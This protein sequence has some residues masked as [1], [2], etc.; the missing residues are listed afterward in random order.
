VKFEIA[1]TGAAAEVDGYAIARAL[2]LRVFQDAR[3]RGFQ[4]V[5]SLCTNAVTRYLALGLQGCR[6]L[7]EVE[8]ATF[9]HQGRRVFADAARHRGVALVEGRLA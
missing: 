2:E 3:A 9:E 7:A 8:Y 1:A 4:R 5:V 6:L